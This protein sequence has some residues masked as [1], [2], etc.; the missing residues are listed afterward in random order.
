MY[1]SNR[2]ILKGDQNIKFF[3]DNNKRKYV[4]V[5]YIKNQFEL[6]ITVPTISKRLKVSIG[7]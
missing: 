3:N 6:R 4:I 1:E 7:E 5:K 2:D